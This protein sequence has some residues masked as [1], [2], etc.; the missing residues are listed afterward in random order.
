MDSK[1]LLR[2]DA[3]QLHQVPAQDGFLFGVVQKRPGV[4][5]ASQVAVGE[6]S[7]ELALGINDH[8]SARASPRPSAFGENLAERQTQI[9]SSLAL[10]QWR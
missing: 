10:V 7:A 3:K 1:P 5:Q 4:K 6:N 2:R 8:D 9:P